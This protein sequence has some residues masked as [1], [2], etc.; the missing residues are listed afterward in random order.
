M[1]PPRKS[2]DYLSRTP[3][4]DA[5]AWDRAREGKKKRE[6]NYSAYPSHATCMRDCKSSE[7]IHEIIMAVLCSC[8]DRG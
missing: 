1:T 4:T 5:V 6:R 8:M 2:N 3:V 7:E